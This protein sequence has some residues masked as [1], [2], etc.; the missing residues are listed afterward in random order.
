M[1]KT[2]ETLIKKIVEKGAEYLESRPEETEFDGEKVYTL[3]GEKSI[4]LQDIGNRAM[5]G[6]GLSPVSYTHL[7][8]CLLSATEE[9]Q[10]SA[11]L[12][13]SE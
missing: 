1:V 5:C 13:Y 10:Y 6:N 4:S 2:C 12:F 11:R 7:L 3:D 9:V 8:L